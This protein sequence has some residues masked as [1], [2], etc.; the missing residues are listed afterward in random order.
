MGDVEEEQRLEGGFVNEVVRVGDTVR[1]TAGPWTPAVHTLLQHLEQA[2]FRE[3]PRAHGLDQQGREI[4]TFLPGETTPWTN[5]PAVLQR[6]DGLI[7]MGQLLRRYH[8]AVRGFVPP[9]GAVWRNPLAPAEGELIR[10]GD[11]SPFN[12]LWQDDRPTGII[13]WD[14]AQ[15]GQAITDLA[16]LAWNAV[17]L[18]GIGRIREYGLAEDVDLP[19]RLSALCTAYDETI[20][21]DEVVDAAIAAIRTEAEQTAALAERGLHPWQRFAQDGNVEAFRRE[22]DWIQQ[23]RGLFLQTC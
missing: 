13:D 10:H 2:D 8:D 1:R 15:P 12:I 19:A 11:F 20:R 18:Q 5:W 23:N 14:F 16:Y 21:P 22:A 3:S 7:M 9:A 4:L 17:P 6:V